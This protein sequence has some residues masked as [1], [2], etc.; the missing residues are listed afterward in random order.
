MLLQ[1]TINDVRHAVIAALEDAFPDI[2]VGGA[3]IKRNL[4]PPCFCVELLE[5]SHTQEL[6]RRFVRSLPFDVQYFAANPD[7]EA[8]YDVAEQLTGLLQWIEAG[9]RM[10]R[11]MGIRFQ[12]VE[13]VLHFY[14][15]YQVHVWAPQPEVPAMQTLDVR[16]GLK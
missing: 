12:V 1:V 14:V 9:G 16:E 3:E 2:P 11:G 8:L 6:G 10:T 13:D 15:E 4:A 7:S 5:A